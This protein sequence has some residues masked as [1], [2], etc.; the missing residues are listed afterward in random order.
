M[1]NE[2]ECKPKKTSV[3]HKLH[4]VLLLLLGRLS[5]H[6]VTKPILDCSSSTE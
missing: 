5:A 2:K 4:T 1:Q 3:A 6:T